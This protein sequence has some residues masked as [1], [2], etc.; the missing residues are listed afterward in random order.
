MVICRVQTNLI[1]EVNIAL[2]LLK[3]SKVVY[4]PCNASIDSASLKT[5]VLERYTL[6]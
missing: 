2:C 4:E 3:N 6:T 1:F 5:V